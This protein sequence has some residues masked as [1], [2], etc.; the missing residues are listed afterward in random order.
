MAIVFLLILVLL[1]GMPEPWLAKF[2]PCPGTGAEA[3]ANVKVLAVSPWLD[4]PR[5]DDRAMAVEIGVGLSQKIYFFQWFAPGTAPV[6]RLRQE[7]ER[8][9]MC[10]EGVGRFPLPR[11]DMT[12]CGE[13]E[14]FSPGGMPNPP[15]IP[16][17]RM[18]VSCRWH[19]TLAAVRR[20]R[21]S[22][23]FMPTFST[24]K[25]TV[26]TRRGGARHSQPIDLSGT[27]WGLARLLRREA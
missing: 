26:A 25:Q 12:R 24:R 15:G 27:W 11:S 1:V 6:V 2:V 14:D 7:N 4:R 3:P 18:L 21:N 20:K 22:C 19:G 23:R 8:K 13:R 5:A 10:I 16:G 17:S 9:I